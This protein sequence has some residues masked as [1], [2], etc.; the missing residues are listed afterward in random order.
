MSGCSLVRV[1]EVAEGVFEENCLL[2]RHIG[3]TFAIMP[4]GYF[5]MDE[6]DETGWG[7]ENY[8]KMLEEAGL[9]DIKSLFPR[10][11][12]HK[13]AGEGSLV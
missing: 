11:R 2:T 4:S 10:G 1:L 12:V 6:V 13:L 7:G 9:M 3:R 5:D 8:V